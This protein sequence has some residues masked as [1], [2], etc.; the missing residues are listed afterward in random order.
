MDSIHPLIIAFMTFYNFGT[1][2]LDL[3]SKMVSWKKRNLGYEVPI[4]ATSIPIVVSWLL[5]VIAICVSTTDNYLWTFFF[6]KY[7]EMDCG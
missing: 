6:A 4:P 2:L 3:I 7:I 1:L 5:R